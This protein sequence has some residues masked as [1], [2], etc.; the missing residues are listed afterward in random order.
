MKYIFWFIVLFLFSSYSFASDEVQVSLSQDTIS[1]GENIT[2]TIEVHGEILSPENLSFDIPW[3]EN[4]SVFSQSISNQSSNINGQIQSFSVYSFHL[5]ARDQ[6]DFTLGPIE[7]FSW[8]WSIVDEEIV[9]IRVQDE[10]KQNAAVLPEVWDDIDPSELW[11]SGGIKPLREVF[12]PW[13]GIVSGVF[14]FLSIFYL[15]LSYI[16]SQQKKEIISPAPQNEVV[17][18]KN[19]RIKQY[20]LSL[21]TENKSLVSQKFFKKYNAWVRQMLFEKGI[22]NAHKAT[23]AELQAQAWIEL[24]KE[25]KIFIKSYKYEYSQREISVETRKEYINDIVT[26]LEK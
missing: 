25:Y 11:E 12:F 16:L 18:S 3:I 2:Y 24:L 14:A 10:Q 9:N 23:L 20:F 19:E 5:Q 17:I 6:W 4:F 1:I 13:W 22:I 15:L 26:I 7:I 8:S 21:E